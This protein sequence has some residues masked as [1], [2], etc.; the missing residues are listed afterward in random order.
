MFVSVV[1]GLFD[2]PTTASMASSFANTT[3]PTWWLPITVKS[4]SCC[5]I[6]M[7]LILVALV[8]STVVDTESSRAAMALSCAMVRGLADTERVS[9]K[10]RKKVV[11]NLNL[12]INIFVTVDRKTQWALARVLPPP[13]GL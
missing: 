3:K 13:I 6:C 4:D 9:N 11:N 12:I 2:T 1:Y 7:L 5:S 8:S 10:V